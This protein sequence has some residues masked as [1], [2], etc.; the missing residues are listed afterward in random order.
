MAK[1]N[2]FPRVALTAALIFAAAACTD[3]PTVTQV[4]PPVPTAARPEIIDNGTE[5]ILDM[6]QSETLGPVAETGFAIFRQSAFETSSG[7]GQ[8]RPFLKTSTNDT[9][10]TAFNTSSDSKP[11][12]VTTNDFT[13]DLPL[14]WVPTVLI[15]GLVYREIRLDLNEPLN[16]TDDLLSLDRFELWISSEDSIPSL[17]NNL[18]NFGVVGDEALVYQFP[19][20]VTTW[21]RMDANL[22][23]GSGGGDVFFYIPETAFGTAGAQCPYDGATTLG[24]G[25]FLTLIVRFGDEITQEGTF[26]EFGVR[27]L[28][29][30]TKTATYKY[31]ET[32]SWTITKKVKK[33]T[34]AAF[35]GTS[36][37][38]DL[39]NG[40]NA[41]AN[42]EV[43]VDK[44]VVRTNNRVE[45]VITIHN[46]TDGD[47][48][49]SNVTD[50]FDGTTVNVTCP[51]ATVVKNSTLDC[52]YTV[53]LAAA[54]TLPQFNTA[55]AQISN[56]NLTLSIQGKANVAGPGV[57]GNTT[58][59]NTINVT[60]NF[61]GGGA[62]ALGSASDDKTFTPAN[63]VFACATDQG[64]K[65]NVATITETAQTAQA[66]VTTN[67][68]NLT[69]TKTAVPAQGDLFDWTILKQVTP[70]SR[71]MYT[72]DEGE[73]RYTVTYTKG[74]PTSTHT[75]SGIVTIA[76][77]AASSGN[78]SVAAPTD[79][80]I[81]AGGN[82]AIPVTLDC[83]V[84]AF[85]R[86][87]APG[88]SFQCTYSN[89]L[90]PNG[91]ART[92]RASVQGT[93]PTNNSKSFNGDA[94]FDFTGVTPS[95][96]NNA[97]S[98]ADPNDPSTPRGPFTASGSFNYDKT[99]ACGIT[100]TINNTATM[101]ST[102]GL[103]KTSNAS[104][105]ITCVE[106]T[107][108]K[109]SDE[110]FRRTYLWDIT[111]SRGLIEG[112]PAPSSLILQT[113]Q[114][115]LYPYSVRVFTTG[116]TD[117]QHS[118]DG[119][120]QVT[121][122]AGV[123]GARSFTISDQITPGPYD[124]SVSCTGGNPQSITG[125]GPINCTWGPIDLPDAT[126]RTNTATARLQNVKYLVAG[127]TSNLSTTDFT[128]T[129]PVTFPT[130][131]TSVRDNCVKVVD[132]AQHKDANGGGLGSLITNQL[133]GGNFTV[134]VSG[135]PG[136]ADQ[137][138]DY[139][140]TIGPM[141]QFPPGCGNY[142]FDNTATLTTNTTG[143]TASDDLQT[144][145]TV[146]CPQA[147]TLTQGYWKTHNASFGAGKGKNAVRR[148][149]PIHDW[150]ALVNVWGPWHTWR[151][152]GGTPEPVPTG[153]TPVIVAVPNPPIGN[154]TWFANFQTAPSGNPYYQASHQFMAAM[155]NVANGAPL[156]PINTELGNAYNFFLTASPNT[157][158]S[159][160][161]ITQLLAWN[162]LF[163][164][165]NEGTL[166]TLHCTEDGTSSIVP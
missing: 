165:Y 69:V 58:G 138:L 42:Y 148:G 149:P 3:R 100:R 146:E 102:D 116:H 95:T 32:V 66:S 52:P 115:F 126:S 147:C 43:V 153:A 59:Y 124:P 36:V 67:C 112:S 5:V 151:F 101:T 156:A 96:T 33:S 49:V 122:N 137:T 71:T 79:Q 12:T 166:G 14:S 123:P 64:T 56:A 135:S 113:G 24:C 72:G 120:I 13:R 4:P 29:Y 18:P 45:G 68:Y 121:G 1:P 27:K 91:S 21:M 130:A 136:S 87:L 157:N 70:A 25:K 139:T 163:G 40:D 119:T 160:P 84:G 131:P 145:I 125:A 20:N 128:G 81:A 8:V 47:F 154:P 117:D 75:V 16:G 127:G 10:L 140:T 23:S 105:T 62:V 15:G 35:T 109:T 90:L 57:L 39:W 30:L 63:Q 85:P 82:P 88:G 111:K 159:Q 44:S 110:D 94:P 22:S 50:T 17:G 104:I 142:R 78:I 77:P 133:T 51:S 28:P 99:H 143:A 11:S 141:S 34:D 73:F 97:V 132:V 92:N 107:V 48:S 118:A 54:P 80:I 155:L 6:D 65:N 150:G 89:V 129:A 98:I 152:F 37:T 2:R 19:T 9:E 60:D 144:P 164:S 134:C 86:I 41:T 55:T 38:F 76:N 74:A 31:D 83:G 7:T 106:P 161:Q 26:E 108:T 158:W 93:I 61:D 46:Q 114:T 53:N 103:N 162:S